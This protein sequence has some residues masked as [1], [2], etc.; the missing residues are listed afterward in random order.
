MISQGTEDYHKSDFNFADEVK[1]TVC[2]DVKNKSPKVIERFLGSV[3]SEVKFK[4]AL[5]NLVSGKAITNFSEPK[6]ITIRQFWKTLK[7]SSS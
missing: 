6:L 4:K 1:I 2:L 3:K 7:E 5:D